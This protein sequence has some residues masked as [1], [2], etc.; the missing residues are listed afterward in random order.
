MSD[1]Y[2]YTKGMGNVGSYLI[3]GIPYAT[4]SITVAASNGGTPTKIEFPNVTRFV[5]VQ[6]E[7]AGGTIRVGFSQAGVTGSVDNY[8]GTVGA[9]QSITF[10]VRVKEIY[11]LADG[12][13]AIDKVSVV[14]GLTGISNVNLPTNWSGSVGV[15]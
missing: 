5:T 15:G 7:D 1:F 8:Y 14:A 4:G 9:Q 13:S 2:K 12:T 10:D 6:N 3:S 11:L